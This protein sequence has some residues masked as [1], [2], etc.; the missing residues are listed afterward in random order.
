MSGENREKSRNLEVENGWQ[1]CCPKAGIWPRGYKT[2]FLLSSI[3][4]EILNA[5]KYKN[6]KKFGFC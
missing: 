1:L 5:H 6:I 2:F 4:H 3:E